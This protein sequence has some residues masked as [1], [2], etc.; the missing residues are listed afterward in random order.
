MKKNRMVITPEG[1]TEI[2]TA[3]IEATN[4]TETAM[5]AEAQAP[6][7]Q[8]APEPEPEPPTPTK[9]RAEIIEET[10]ARVDRQLTLANRWKETE[11]R[12]KEFSDGLQNL[13]KD[14]CRIRLE[15]GDKSF[16]STDPETARRFLGIQV[17]RFKCEMEEIETELF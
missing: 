1:K 17:D 6:G 2:E 15:I 9:S 8:A 11:K 5:E 16:V 13:D 10:F 4:Q 14:R 7:S 12:F 3:E